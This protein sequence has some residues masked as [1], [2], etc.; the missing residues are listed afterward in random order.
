MKK[1]KIGIAGLG[2]VGKSVYQIIT[3]DA[4]NLAKKHDVD[5]EIVAVSARSNKDF[6]N[7]DIKFYENALDLANDSEIDIVVEV[8]GGC[9]L[10]KDLAIKTLSN[11]K[12]FVTANK[13][14][15]AEHGAEISKI[16]DKNNCHIGFEASTVGALPIIKSF[17]ENFVAANDVKEF[18][19]I[20]NG[21]CNFILTKMANENRD[22][23]DVLKEAQEKGYAEADP[24][25]D[26][27]GIDAA[28]KLTIL[29]AIACGANPNFKDQHIEGIDKIEASDIKLAKELGYEIKLL[30]IFKNDQNLITQA[31]YPALIS[32]SSM[33]SKIEGTFNTV[34]TN[35]SNA[36]WSM[37]VGKGAGGLITASAIVADIVDIA[38]QF[39][40]K[41]FLIASGK[42]T[43]IK[44]KSINDR[45]GKYFIKL[46]LEKDNITE[47]REFLKKIIN[48][49]FEIDQISFID[50][51]NEIIAGFIT[52]PNKE[53]KILSFIDQV[54]SNK[55]KLAKFIRVEDPQF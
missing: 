4:K 54:N 48:E 30:G 22:F 15:L 29:S 21:T 47:D 27:K 35:C 13:A 16:A 53:S 28:H 42:L 8:I 45:F 39:F 18:Y 3:Q 1:L 12:H 9:G 33:I 52:N 44:I 38:N 24:T 6:V 37:L 14:L 46:I 55:I 34:V 32:Q 11:K 40:S 50:E 41:V 25:F 7:K 17:K 19:G 49:N 51:Q 23:N 43:N 36:S 26:I 10:A 20:L 5:F 2:T 31:V